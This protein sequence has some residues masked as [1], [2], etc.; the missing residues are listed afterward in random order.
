[1]S[2]KK[3]LKK[4][5]RE[6]HEEFGPSLY[7]IFF[8]A[9]GLITAFIALMVATF[10]KGPIFVLSIAGM[11]YSIRQVIKWAEKE[12]PVRPV[13]PTRQNPRLRGM[14]L[15]EAHEAACKEDSDYK[16]ANDKFWGQ[17]AD[18]TEKAVGHRDFKEGP[19]ERLKK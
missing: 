13:G 18:E 9:L 19:L 15:D 12:E 17:I 8:I 14:S 2:F 3:N 1:L 16:A 11:I 5:I 6:M 7:F 10:P 4:V